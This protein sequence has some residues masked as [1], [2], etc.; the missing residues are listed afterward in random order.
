MVQKVLNA[1]PALATTAALSCDNVD[2]SRFKPNSQLV[3]VNFPFIDHNVHYIMTSAAMATFSAVAIGAYDAPATTKSIAPFVFSVG[4]WYIAKMACRRAAVAAQ[5]WADTYRF[6]PAQLTAATTNTDNACVR[7]HF[8]RL[9]CAQNRGEL[10]VGSFG[11]VLNAYC[12]SAWKSGLGCD[13]YGLNWYH[14]TRLGN[15]AT[16]YNTSPVAGDALIMSVYPDFLMRTMLND[17]YLNYCGPALAKVGGNWIA[18][19]GNQFPK[20]AGAGANAAR[21]LP[22]AI[23]LSSFVPNDSWPV[24]DDATRL[25]NAK[26]MRWMQYARIV[27][28]NPLS[29]DS[30]L[31]DAYGD[32]PAFFANNTTIEAHSSG[33]ATQAR[34]DVNM[35]SLIWP[36][37][38]FTSWKYI[39]EQAN[40]AVNLDQIFLMT[41]GNTSFRFNAFAKYGSETQAVELVPGADIKSDPFNALLMAAEKEVGGERTA[42]PEFNQNE[43]GDQQ[44]SSF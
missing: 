28:A 41:S 27:D 33:E 42:E 11:G 37:C 18:I 36:V 30:V 14:Y 23:N 9:Y 19:K 6:S 20:G 22:N 34:L 16:N 21:P 25:W 32:S 40:G 12:N 1:V 39:F 17:A 29:F 24:D 43:G 15:F 8:D 4:D 44:E 5:L 3:P 38:D 35:K 26:F 31:S 2:A 13:R 7:R 10:I